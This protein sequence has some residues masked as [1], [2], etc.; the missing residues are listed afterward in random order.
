MLD[1]ACALSE[2]ERGLVFV[3]LA[4]FTAAHGAGDRA[5]LRY[6][7]EGL[8]V[9]FESRPPIQ[10]KLENPDIADMLARWHGD[11]PAI[12]F[13]DGKTT[14]QWVFLRAATSPAI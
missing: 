10:L 1:V 7:P 4:P 2:T 13:I 11:I 6:T 14:R 3:F 8:S 9:E 12:E 5:I